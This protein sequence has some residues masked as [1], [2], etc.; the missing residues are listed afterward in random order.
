MRW[1]S[2]SGCLCS[3]SRGE[4]LAKGSS[5]QGIRGSLRSAFRRDNLA[6]SSLPAVAFRRPRANAWRGSDR[7]PAAGRG[8]RTNPWSELVAFWSGWPNRRLFGMGPSFEVYV[9]REIFPDGANSSSERT[10][11]LSAAAESS[12][13]L[14]KL[15]QFQDGVGF[16]FRGGEVVSESMSSERRAAGGRCG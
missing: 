16:L 2:I 5:R 9:E 8:A 13:L 6:G 11:A 3:F 14:F 1:P 7:E 4:E 15:S 10:Q 12:G